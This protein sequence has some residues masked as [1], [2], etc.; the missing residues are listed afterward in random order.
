MSTMN[1]TFKHPDEIIDFLKT[2]CKFDFNM[3]MRRGRAVVDAKSLLGIMNLGLNNVIELQMYADDCTELERQLEDLQ[4]KME[5]KNGMSGIC[6]ASFLIYYTH[7][8]GYIE[9]ALPVY[10]VGVASDHRRRKRVPRHILCS[11]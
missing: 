5:H 4:H 10:D 9:C 6:S 2:V 11:G 8:S 1:I 3:D 7:N